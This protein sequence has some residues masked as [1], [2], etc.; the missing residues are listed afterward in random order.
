MS[1]TM[2]QNL[3][4][5]MKR[6]SVRMLEAIRYACAQHLPRPSISIFRVL[7][8]FCEAAQASGSKQTFILMF[9]S[10]GLEDTERHFSA[11]LF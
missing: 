4:Q 9:W 6:L 1:M 8:Q 10:E 7:A 11:F 2:L 3:Q 5:P